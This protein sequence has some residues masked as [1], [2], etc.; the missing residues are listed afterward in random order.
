[1]NLV[2]PVQLSFVA[3]RRGG[4]KRHYLFN[5]DQISQRSKAFVADP[6]YDDQMFR[7]AKRSEFVAMLDDS[8]G[9]TLPNSRQRFQFVRGS[10]VDVDEFWC[11]CGRLLFVRVFMNHDMARAFDASREAKD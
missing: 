6:A 9:Q 5:R 10:S 11:G 8:L 2:N 7:A 4:A 1:M 3:H